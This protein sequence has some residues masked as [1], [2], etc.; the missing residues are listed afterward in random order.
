MRRSVQ[1]ITLHCALVA[2][3][4][5]SIL[6]ASRRVGMHHTALSRRIRELEQAL[7]VSL[8]DR[9][10]GGVRPTPAGRQFID[11][12]R[13]NLT[14]LDNTLTLV[15]QTA[16]GKSGNLSI[17]FEAPI[18]AGEVLGTVT[19]FLKDR[20]SV[21][22]RFREGAIESLGLETDRDGVDLII[23]FEPGE[24]QSASSLALCAEPVVVAMAAGHPLAR[25]ESIETTALRGQVL[26]LPDPVRASWCDPLIEGIG[27]PHLRKAIVRHDI[28]RD[29][30]LTLVREGLGVSLL[31]QREANSEIT[32]IRVA[33]LCQGAEPVSM[34]Y[35][36][37]W[38][39]T[40]ANPVLAC[41]V[42][43]LRDRYGHS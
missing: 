16:A 35:F 25:S 7:G 9:H 18:S 29:S 41:F 5:G 10:P 26:L 27:C 43:F 13:A 38:S 33:P 22:V 28:C 8:F 14:D 42:G 21:G 6:T 12:L 3:E 23:G 11:R 30:L 2:A 39:S 40:N 20:P 31:R 4:E 15:Q 32:G 36:A 24:R 17:G 34:R 37:R 19:D 1:L